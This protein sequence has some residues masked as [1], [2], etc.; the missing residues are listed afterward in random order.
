[1]GA[2]VDIDAY[3]AAHRHE[4]ARLAELTR[5]GGR[6]RGDEVDELVTLYHRTA[7]HLSVV[8]SSFP[9]PSLVARL[10]RLVADA[11]AA[12]TGSH[13]PAWRDAARFLTVSFP[14]AVYRAWP[15]WTGAAAAFVLVGTLVGW[16]VAANPEVQATIAA[17]EEIRQLVEVEF[18]EYYSSHPAGSFA[19]QVWTNNAWVAAMSIAGGVLLG[20]PVLW[21][22][23]QNA[24]N[25]G[26][27]GGLMAANGRAGLFFGLILPHGL[28]ELT[29]VFIAAG[30][31][32][33]IGWTVVDP[34]PRTRSRA[35]AEEGRAAGGVVLGL[36]LVLLVSGVLEAFVTPSPL[37]TW[38]RIAVG[39]AVEAAFLAYVV[40]LG[41][42]AVAHG[43]TGDLRLGEREDVAPVAA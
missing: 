28:L 35:L 12:V 10:S 37:P 18:E 39:A 13:T 1:M 27:A 14:A 22:L 32:L 38:A 3:V 25:V 24:L 34:G 11:R 43:E 26:I 19:A 7:T 23:W 30:V 5:R 16:W 17:P 36:V 21:V 6:L 42:R 20:L 31:G 40:V 29:A 33:R 9:D 4:W 2:C 8:R 15:W 41:R